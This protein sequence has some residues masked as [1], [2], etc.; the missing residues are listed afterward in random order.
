[1]QVR[2]STQA[3][4]DLQ[5]IREW[6]APDNLGRAV[7]FIQELRDVIARIGTMPH[8]FPLIPRYERHGI[9]RRSY[10][11]YGILYSVQPDRLFVH[12]IIGP[13]QD[14]DRAL[15]LN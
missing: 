2:L 12:R 5:A 6:I 13:G 11:G 10:K 4:R 15:R 1:M 14:H 3:I 9:R 8:A 7:T